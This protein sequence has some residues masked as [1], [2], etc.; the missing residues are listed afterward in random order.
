MPR[1]ISAGDTGFPLDNSYKLSIHH[2]TKVIRSFKD[3]FVFYKR[4][5]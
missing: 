3:F 2:S 4:K 5:Y 1:K